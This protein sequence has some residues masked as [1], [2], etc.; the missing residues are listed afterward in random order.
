MVNVEWPCLLWAVL[1][2]GRCFW[3]VWER[4]LRSCGEQAGK[5]RTSVASSQ[6]PALT[7]FDDGL[8]PASQRCPFLPP[9]GLWEL[10]CHSSKTQTRPGRMDLVFK[11]YYSL[12]YLRLFCLETESHLSQAG[13]K[14]IVEL[15]V[16]LSSFCFYS[17][18]CW[19][20]KSVPP[21]HTHFYFLKI[22]FLQI[23]M[24]KTDRQLFL[25]FHSW[26]GSPC[27]YK[28]DTHEHSV[29]V[30]C[31]LW[32][33]LCPSILLANIAFILR[34]MYYSYIRKKLRKQGGQM[35]KTTSCHRG[36]EG[37]LW[38]LGLDPRS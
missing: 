1:P 32:F 21:H 14:L 27:R 36:W 12:I 7:S 25:K 17:P 22:I 9:N 30:Y 31:M 20:Y 28:E 29:S 4:N 8:W 2:L 10:S 23:D 11:F 35:W 34:I 3:A 26:G 24:T 18:M 38:A 37:R 15:S 5:E 33:Y 16:T 19:C 13:L 6:A